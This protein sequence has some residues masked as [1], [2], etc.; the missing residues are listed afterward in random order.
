MAKNFLL[1]IDPTIAAAIRARTYTADVAPLINSFTDDLVFEPDLYPLK[2]P[3]RQ[4]AFGQRWIGDDDRSGVIFQIKQD[5]N[6]SGSGHVLKMQNYGQLSGVT[7]DFY[8]PGGMNGDTGPLNIIQYPWAIELTGET[9]R[10]RIDNISIQR[11]FNGINASGNCGGSNF[12]RIE[13]GSISTGLYLG[14]QAA[15]PADFVTIESWESWVYGMSAALSQYTY[16][17]PG[18]VLVNFCD[19]LVIGTMNLWHKRFVHDNPS[20]LATTI[21]ALKLDGGDAHVH[22]KQGR[23]SIGAVSGLTDSVQTALIWNE[24]GTTTIGSAQ[25]KVSEHP[26]LIPYELDLVRCDSGYLSIA[27][28]ALTGH[29]NFPI[30]RLNGVAS[31]DE[32]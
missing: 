18:Q 10:V 25:L 19:G 9:T 23:L 17:N 12:S 24:G 13:D 29:S 28:G 20:K 15:G 2:T 22:N 1:S 27:T 31:A 16:N 4:A 14:T 5:F 6:D 30:V 26:N 32:V 11:A 8:Q 7:L 21:G 3:A